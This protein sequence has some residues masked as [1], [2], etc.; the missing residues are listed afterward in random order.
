LKL[1][2]QQEAIANHTLG[3]ALVFAVAGSGKT[4]CMVHRIKR[5][6]DKRI[7]APERIL[8]TSFNNS[9][10]QDI[11]ALLAALGISPKVNCRTLHALGY[12]II[13]SA[14][15]RKYFGREWLNSAEPE[16]LHS[17]LVGQTITQLAIENGVD[18]SELNIDRE[19]LKNQISIWKG[20]LIY[21]DL[22]KANLPEPGRKLARQASHEHDLYVRAYQTYEK[23]RQRRKV[24][25]FDDMLMLGWEV[26]IRYPE[27]LRAVQRN[28]Q[29]VIVDEFQDVNYAQYRIMDLI[30]RPHRNYMAI[31]DDDQCIYEWRGASPEFILNFKK[32]Y[33]AKV[34][35]ISD[36]FR[37]AAQ[38]IVL[39]NKIIFRNQNRYPKHLSLTRG[40]EGKTYL[41]QK[42]NNLEIGRSIVREI[43]ELLSGGQTSAADMVILIRLYSQTAFLETAFIENQI[44]YRIEGSQPFY[45]RNELVVLFQY[46]S[47]AEYERDI[48]KNGFPQDPQKADKYL[49]MFSGIINIPRRYVAKEFVQF[50]IRQAKRR[51]CSVIE[52]MLERRDDL[53]GRIQTRVEDFAKLTDRLIRKLNNPA[54]KTLKWLVEEIEYRDYLLNISGIYEVGVSKIQ[55]V[56]ALIEFAKT[57]KS[58]CRSFLEFIR[59][60]SLHPVPNPQ[61]L[62]PI[63]IM[64]IYRAKGL[65]WD[66]VFVPGCN[67]GLIPCAMAG[68][69]N[70]DSLLLQDI[71]AERRL[72]YVAVTRA[73]NTLHLYYSA[74]KPTSP[75]LTEVNA[76]EILQEV[77]QMRTILNRSRSLYRQKELYRF[78]RNIADFHLERYFLLWDKEYSGSR[79]SVSKMLLENLERK[80]QQAEREYQ[81]YRAKLKE[82][83]E[84]IR[85]HEQRKQEI[86]DKIHSSNI[87]V[88]KFKS[89]FYPVYPGDV[90]RFELLEEQDVMAL[91]HRGL[92]GIVEFDFMPEFDKTMILWNISEAVVKNISPSNEMIEAKFT[93]A[94]TN[95]DHPLFLSREGA[96]PKEPPQKVMQFLKPG[97]LKGVEILKRFTYKNLKR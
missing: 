76:E 19:D 4:T 47:F 79:D 85:K 56:D 45:R 62:P 39:A 49:Q 9:A 86:Q 34:Y 8:A 73:K 14:V 7:F 27:I 75:F 84:A 87:V 52:F 40:F 65:E 15:Y 6:I 10:V 97:F 11:V 96:K 64:T 12:G 74:E 92:V 82:Y 91:S 83:E 93:G 35:T 95:E 80:I 88:R 33:N 71:E 66:A 41:H 68:D 55:T 29:T 18:S 28:Y 48:R 5:L 23:I 38:Q 78:C 72:F 36:N 53:K 32:I 81:K 1:T 30:T 43:R 54:F 21:P 25:T 57:T 94:I 20:N 63:K 31:G 61:N 59:D 50:V 89:A 51:Q 46:L 60:I 16:E 69:Q 58:K 67:D 17:Q 22:E 44:P 90:L 26:L 3:P 13:R 24:I 37:S 2:D 70:D 42:E 77:E